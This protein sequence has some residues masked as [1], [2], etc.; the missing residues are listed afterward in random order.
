MIDKIYQLLEQEINGEEIRAFAAEYQKYPLQL[1]YSA[2]AQGLAHVCGIYEEMGLEAELIK[3]PADGKTVY[4]DRHYPLAWDVDSAWAEVDG[5]RI[6]DYEQATY[7]VVPFSA[8]SG[9]ICEKKLMPWKTCRRKALW[10]TMRRSS[11]T[12]LPARK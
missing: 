5:E 9:G 12:T 1:S 4:A 11:A 2:Y 7:S 8:D 3:F 10:K 6:A